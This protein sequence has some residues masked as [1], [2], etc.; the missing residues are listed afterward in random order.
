M[1]LMN[2]KE[3]K[4]C[5]SVDEDM[6]SHQMLFIDLISINDY[7]I[8]SMKERRHG[9]GQYK[10]SKITEIERRFTRKID[11]QQRGV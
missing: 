2:K 3:E 1:K 5:S 7:S 4:T 8:T 6:V 11:A 10:R 9:E